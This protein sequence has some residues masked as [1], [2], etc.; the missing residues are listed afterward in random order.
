MPFHRSGILDN[1]IT[2]FVLKYYYFS[3][4]QMIV[5]ILFYCF[6]RTR[7][8]DIDYTHRINKRFST[9]AAFEYDYK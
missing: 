3:N 6:R 5:T 1:Y 2:H 7:I 9:V 4:E 8:A